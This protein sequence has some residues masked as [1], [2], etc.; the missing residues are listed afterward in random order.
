MKINIGE[1]YTYND[2]PKSYLIEIVDIDEYLIRVKFHENNVCFWLDK[3][4]FNAR[5]TKII[6]IGPGDI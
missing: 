2:Y 5:C 4:H 1:K 6:S 3:N